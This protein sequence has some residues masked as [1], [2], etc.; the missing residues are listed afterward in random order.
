MRL[1]PGEHGYGLISKLLHW[2]VFL[3]LMA[4]FVIG[5]SIDRA[6][7]LLEPVVDRWFS[8]EEEGLLIVHALLGVTILALALVRLTW[9]KVAGLPPWAEQLSAAERWLQHALE[10]ALYSLQFLIPI[11]G[12]ALLFL[13]GEDWDLNGGEW[14]APLELFDDD[15]L[16]GAHIFTHLVFFV[17][18]TLHVGLVLKHQVL[19]RDGLLRRML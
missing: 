16:L 10:R 18:F 11:T 2:T 8:G 3:A 19:Q 7:D 9:R 12:L 13:S 6:D 15:F 14:E 17:A 4:Q 5:Y 1:V